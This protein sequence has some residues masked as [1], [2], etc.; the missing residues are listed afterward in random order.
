MVDRIASSH[1]WEGVIAGMVMCA[2]WVA[3]TGATLPAPLTP[4]LLNAAAAAGAVLLL[5]CGAVLTWRWRK[6]RR[7]TPP[8]L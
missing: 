2:T 3:M 7:E 6:S 4:A 5:V 1:L 8:V